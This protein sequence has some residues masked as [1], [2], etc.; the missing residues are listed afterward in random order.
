MCYCVIIL[1][2]S[3]FRSFPKQPF[4]EFPFWS[5]QEAKCGRCENKEKK[6]APKRMRGHSVPLAQMFI[7]YVLHFIYS[8][9]L[10]KDTSKF[11]SYGV[12]YRNIMTGI[13]AVKMDKKGFFGFPFIFCPT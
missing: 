9:Y 13:F 3:L 5:K 11:A 1:L 4:G 8:V 10:L 7:K 12:D 6:Q 2:F